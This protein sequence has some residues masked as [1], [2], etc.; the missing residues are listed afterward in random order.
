MAIRQQVFGVKGHKQWRN[1]IS[2]V[3]IVWNIRL[4]HISVERCVVLSSFRRIPFSLQ[5][6]VKHRSQ[7][8]KNM[9]KKLFVKLDKT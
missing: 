9:F 6:E 5:E 7:V 3:A 2:T 4:D 8:S 1:S